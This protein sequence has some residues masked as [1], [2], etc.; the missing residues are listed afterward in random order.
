MDLFKIKGI[1]E[2]NGDDAKKELESVNNT[3]S[4]TFSKI[5]KG[6]ATVGKVMAGAFAVGATA[7]T[8]MVTKS[9]QSYAEY[10]QLVGGVDTLFKDSSDKVQEYAKKAYETAGLSANDYMETVTSFSAS[11][12]Q[13]LNGDTAKSAEVAD[14]AIRDMSDNA[15]KM[16]TS[17]ESIQNA[18]QGFAKQNYTMLDNLKLGYGGTKE[19]MERLLADAE[20]ISGQKYD[21]SNL[22]DVYQAIHVIQG[23]LGITGTTAKEA[24]QTISGSISAMKGAWQNLL[25]AISDD[26]APFDEYVNAFVNSVSTVMDNLL[27]RINEALNGI[28]LLV[29]QLAPKLISAIP[30]VLSKVLPSVVDAV[31]ALIGAIANALPELISV[32][33]EILPSIISLFVELIPQIIKAL[34]STLPSL[35][36]AGVQIISSLL[37]GLGKMI[38]EIIIAIV[39]IIPQIIDALIQGIPQLIAGALQ[40]FMAIVKAIPNVI[41]AIVTALPQIVDSIINGLISA[42]PQ[43]IAGAIQLLNAIVDAIPQILPPLIEAL[44]TIITTIIEGLIGALPQLIEG[45]IQLFMAII[46][47]IPQILPPIMSAV[48][49]IVMAIVGGLL[50]NLPTLIQGAIQLFMGIVTAIPTIIAELIKCGPDIVKGLWQGITDAFKNIDWGG[51]WQGIIDGFKSLFGINSPSTVFSDFGGNIVDGLWNGIKNIGAKAGE[52]WNKLK[53]GAVEKFNEI[54]DKV[55]TKATEIKDKAVNK[56]NELKTNATNKFN[57]MKTNVVNKAKEMASN[58]GDKFN[59]LKSSAS[60]KFGSI[61]DAISD[62]MSDAKQKAVDMFNEMN[63]QSGGKLGNMVSAVGDKFGSIYTKIKDKMGNAKN[64]VSEMLGSMKSAFGNFSAKIKLPHFKFSG[65]LNPAKW[66]DGQAPKLS[67][68][69]YAKGGIFDKPT[70]FDTASGLKGVGEAGPE[71]VAPISKLQDYV[72]VAVA[73]S[74]TALEEK[75]DVLADILLK[76]LPAMQNQ[77]VVLETGALVGQITNQIDRNLGELENKR[78]RGR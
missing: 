26:E 31:G 12:L 71:A 33:T 65:S 67:V 9:I 63:K 56:F 62:K 35:I 28:V 40:F 74:N 36:T 1:V 77:Q 21:I 73:N 52:A 57:D 11:L 54:K 24:S 66:L 14:M 47:A 68:D 64:K 17:M 5:G 25:T 42:I 13:S 2:I 50:E 43:L 32:I 22:N 78:N 20:K 39:E 44:P 46:D 29:Q 18:Y 38:P 55:T 69:W 72:R 37:V 59:S 7:V 75:L 49:Q 51:I 53:T 30:S 45:A 16:G 23:E 34:L 8:A 76:Y 48:P 6:V 58:A 4:S 41:Q 70:L 3:A 15:N 61:K 60:E 27:P 19:E 10:E